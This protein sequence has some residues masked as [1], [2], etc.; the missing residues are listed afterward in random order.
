M[1]CNVTVYYMFSKTWNPEVHE[2]IEQFLYD[3]HYYFLRGLRLYCLCDCLRKYLEVT[4]WQCSCFLFV[5]CNNCDILRGRVFCRLLKTEC[6]FHPFYPYFYP[7]YSALMTGCAVCVWISVSGWKW[8]LTSH[9][10]F[11][12]RWIS[13][14]IFYFFLPFFSHTRDNYFFLFIHYPPFSLRWKYIFWVSFVIQVCKMMCNRKEPAK[15][16]YIN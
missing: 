5:S 1:Y 8:A 10:S 3:S 12:G 11:V 6:S 14:A 13:N 16:S 7:F 15:I 9:L 4:Q 2:D